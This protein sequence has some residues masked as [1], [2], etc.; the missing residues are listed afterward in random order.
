MWPLQ[1]RQLWEQVAFSFGG[2][3]WLT[4]TQVSHRVSCWGLGDSRPVSHFLRLP[5]PSTTCKVSGKPGGKRVKE[6]RIR[7]H[8]CNVQEPAQR[9]GSPCQTLLVEDAVS[10]ETRQCVLIAQ[11]SDSM[12]VCPENVFISEESLG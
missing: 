10:G 11:H 1:E 6:V 9:Q 8:S 2:G 5:L 4:P 3:S 12:S 7:D